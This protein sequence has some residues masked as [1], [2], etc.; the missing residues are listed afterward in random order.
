MN[1]N[2]EEDDKVEE[3]EE[4]ICELQLEIERLNGELEYY[5]SLYERLSIDTKRK[6]NE[7]EY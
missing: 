7:G 3:L 6:L 1:Q 4:K 5:T 2:H